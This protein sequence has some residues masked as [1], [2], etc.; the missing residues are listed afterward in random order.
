[1]SEIAQSAQKLALRAAGPV[2]GVVAVASVLIMT[3]YYDWFLD[4]QAADPC[5]GESVGGIVASCPSML[6]VWGL[7][8][9]MAVFGVGFEAGV[10]VTRK[11]ENRQKEAS[12]SRT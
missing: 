4:A 12:S 2:F 8:G 3:S 7:I 1:M 11:G 6:P 10:W 5:A 9:L